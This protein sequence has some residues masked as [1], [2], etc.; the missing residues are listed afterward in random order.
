MTTS[1]TNIGQKAKYSLVKI[2][3]VNATRILSDKIEFPPGVSS[4]QA[5]VNFSLDDWMNKQ[6]AA[7]IDAQQQNTEQGEV[8]DPQ[9]Q[10]GPSGD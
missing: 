5:R 9:T 3:P 4:L 7:Q 10:P 1:P 6:Q 2:A 8:Q